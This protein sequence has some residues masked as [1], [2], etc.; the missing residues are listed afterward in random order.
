MINVNENEI[1]I[2]DNKKGTFTAAAS[3]RGESVQGFASKVLNNK[4]NYSPAM[5][6]KANFARNAKKWNK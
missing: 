1:K 6:K 4:E 2:K 3:K 5:V